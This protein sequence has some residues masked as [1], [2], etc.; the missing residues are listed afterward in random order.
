M[1]VPSLHDDL[2]LTADAVDRLFAADAK[3]SR[4][5]TRS[6]AQRSDNQSVDEIDDGNSNGV[7]SVG[8]DDGMT[9]NDCVM[10]DD[11]DVKDVDDA[12]DDDNVDDVN[13]SDGVNGNFGYR[14]L[15]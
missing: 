14:Y 5:F 9:G 7:V 6:M 12:N 10:N 13:V 2:I 8:V 3:L 11:V 4:V 15:R 1:L